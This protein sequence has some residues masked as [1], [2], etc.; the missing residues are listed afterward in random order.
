VA[1]EAVTRT[2]DPLEIASLASM[3]E[4]NAPKQYR[5]KELEAA[6]DSL[7]QALHGNLPDRD[8]SPLFETLQSLGDA[9]VVPV[10]KQSAAQWNYYATIALA[11]LPEGAG[12]PALIELAR[13]P[14]VSALGTGDVALRPLAQVAITYPDAARALVEQARADQIPEAAWPTVI[15]SLSGVNIEYGNGMF[16]GT[17]PPVRWTPDEVN[18]RIAL[19]NQLLAVTK[20]PSDRQ[21]LHNAISTLSARLPK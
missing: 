16:G 14:G 11:G 4:Q 7:E 3:L 21:A 20:P 9:S 17:A 8:V 6:R 12:I 10:L 1:A 19:L 18:Q 5:A 2:R 15:A 13:D